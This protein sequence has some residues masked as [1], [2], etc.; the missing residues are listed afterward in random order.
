MGILSEYGNYIENFEWSPVAVDKA[1]AM[2]LFGVV[3]SHKPKKVLEIG[4]GSGFITNTILKALE[5][6]KQGN[7]TC[8]DSWND[9]NGIE[10]NH[11]DSLR[12]RGAKI[13]KSLEQK[14]VES[15]EK[16]KYDIIIADGDHRRS[17]LWAEKTY[18]L[19]K[20][21]GILFFHDV[22]MNAYPKLKRFIEIADEKNY[23]NLLFNQS[24]LPEEMCERGWLLVRKK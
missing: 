11:I 23:T 5:Y 9:W 7:L 15:E 1:H 10:P 24:S 6:N 14:F 22:T 3:A 17:H 4:I 19:A 21:N 2:L 20:S 16:E 8:V 12:K 13:I 18:E